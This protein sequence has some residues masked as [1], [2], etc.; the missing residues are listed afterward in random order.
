VIVPTQAQQLDGPRVPLAVLRAGHFLPTQPLA[1]PSPLRQF[2]LVGRTVR[3]SLDHAYKGMDDGRNYLRYL[4]VWQLGLTRRLQG[5]GMLVSITVTSL[6]VLFAL[7]SGRRLGAALEEVRFAD[8]RSRQA[9]PDVTKGRPHEEL[10]HVTLQL[11]NP[12]VDAGDREAE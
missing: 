6:L 4:S 11:A 1:S 12:P 5:T 2:Q 9:R 7:I 10:D 8:R 3:Y